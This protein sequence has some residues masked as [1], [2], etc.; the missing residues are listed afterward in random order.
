MLTAMLRSA[1]EA[2]PSKTAIV[3]G[4]RRIRYGELDVLA[5]QCAAGL[6]QLGVGASDCVAVALPNCPE[7]VVALFAC[8]R[9]RAIMLPLDPLCS[10][11]ELQRSLSDARAK[12]V[13]TDAPRADLVA[14]SGAVVSEF[15]TL[16]A[17]SADPL[18]ASWSDGPVL[19]L[20]TS[21]STDERK[22]LCCTQKNLYYE[23][24]NFVETMGLTA[25][26]NILCSIP[27]HHSYGLGN[28]LLDAVYAGST[29][30]LLENEDTP[31]A[32]RCERVLQ[33]IRDESIQFYPGVPY[34]F[35]ILAALRL[36]PQPDL[37]GLKLCVSSGD[38]LPRRTY[39]RFRERFGIPI[40]S[41]YG[42]T[43][44]GSIAIDTDPAETMQF[45]TLGLPL[46]HVKVRIRNSSGR[47]LPANESGQIWVKSPVIPPSGYEN[48]PELT[49]QVFREGFYNTGDMGMIDERGHLVL[50]GRKQT[51][52]DVAGRKVDVGEVE[53]VLLNHP[54]V[55]EAA[56]LGVEVANL[57]TL[58][59]AVVVTGGTCDEAEL[60]SFCRERLAAFKIPRLFEFRD[61]L[62]RSP[63]GKVRKSE[64]GGVG[65]Y[66]ASAGPA[67]ID[68]V[69]EA[70]AKDGRG[71]Q[72]ALLALQIQEQAALSLQCEPEVIHRSASFQSMGFDSL[73]AA[74]LH[75]RLVKLTGLPLS[76]TTLW[77][78][79]N[80]DELAAAL[81][82]QM[83]ATRVARPESSKGV[84]EPDTRFQD[85][86]RATK[87]VTT[88]FGEL[89]GEVERMSE[90]D[91]D[92]SFRA[93]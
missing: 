1:V 28:C 32:A 10:R 30:V 59:K 22:R 70:V 18:P 7:F 40:R 84:G 12:L 72:V 2:D 39:E 4:S 49:A 15:E 75:Q 31:F 85:S 57:G 11:A 77:N 93:R 91:V 65:A 73:R 89:L 87:H 36:R 6:H 47:N 53:E 37:A 17:P 24:L 63:A 3:Q 86:G 64:L 78:Y 23:A 51:F 83:N 20:Y 61:E 69:W 62:P 16:L 92:D 81:W 79:P 88:D 56:V 5:G 48:W 33:L 14:G 8:A 45:G 43:E 66:L 44:A 76:I 25:A 29:L 34:Q 26:D 46:K 55:R 90:A 27:L 9:L 60:F 54:H 67:S 74:E 21:G 19:Y 42:S 71:R 80:I 68:P 50:M 58:M 35:Q 41:L 82:A 52:V 38:V 13:I